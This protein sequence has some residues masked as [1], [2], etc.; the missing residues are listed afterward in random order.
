MRKIFTLALLVSL[1]LASCSK[2]VQT[3]GDAA[4]NGRV[5]ISLSFDTQVDAT[6]AEATYKVVC[7]EPSVDDF[8]LV[9]DGLTTDDA[10]EADRRPLSYH[11]EFAKISEFNGEY[12]ARGFY[13]AEVATGDV[14]VEGYDKPAFV[15][16]CDSFQVFPRQEV[17]VEI[18]AT[19]ANAL[20]LVEVTEAF[21][22]YFEG[23]HTFNVVT[24][25]GNT[26]EDVTGA[27]AGEPI[28]INPASFSVVGTATKQVTQSGVEAEVVSFDLT[29]NVEIKPRTLYRVKMDVSNAG[30]ATLKI[31]INNEV[32]EE[33]PIEEELNPWA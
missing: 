5:A 29:P 1:S 21:E 30:G 13:R 19:I 17:D 32:V 11:E 20:V 26:F 6:R 9:V 3:T 8:S 12:I 14:T 7:T 27:K 18:T 16:V 2:D 33:T 4:E 25:A 15:G 22:T 31:T 28:F 23:G 24:A 10:V